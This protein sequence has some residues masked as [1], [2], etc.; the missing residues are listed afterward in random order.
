MNDSGYNLYDFDDV[1]YWFD[2]KFVSR[3]RRGLSLVRGKLLEN[4]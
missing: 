1:L 2:L 4:I 3:F